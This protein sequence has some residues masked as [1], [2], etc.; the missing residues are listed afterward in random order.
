MR[1][2]VRF[3][4]FETMTA[5]ADIARVRQ[6]VGEA[7]SRIVASG[8]LELGGALAAKRS[9][10]F[11]VKDIDDPAQLFDLLG[12]EILDSCHVEALP[13]LSFEQLGEVFRKNPVAS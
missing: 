3:E 10:F 13:I 7:V 1:F 9:G 2:H 12:G 6:G 8:K 5:P 4:V 11:V